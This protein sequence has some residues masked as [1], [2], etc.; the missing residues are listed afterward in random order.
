MPMSS[1]WKSRTSH[2]VS[3]PSPLLDTTGSNK[4]KHHS[5][6][7]IWDRKRV[8]ANIDFKQSNQPP[9]CFEII[10]ICELFPYAESFN[11]WPG[12][13]L[14]TIASQRK[15][16]SH[17]NRNNIFFWLHWGFELKHSTHRNNILCK[18][19]N[20]SASIGNISRGANWKHKLKRKT[21]FLTCPN[22]PTWIIQVN[23]SWLVAPWNR[24]AWDSLKHEKYG[25]GFRLE[26]INSK[27]R[28]NK[29]NVKM[30][31]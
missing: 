5:D 16:R 17:I 6:I 4:T 19:E 26:N 13:S 3:W 2:E 14:G 29:S 22:T 1:W 24:W 15:P 28:Q 27:D 11:V 23:T 12:L 8:Q 30:E 21:R 18:W 20:L 25:C 9:G 7:M 31:E 10:S